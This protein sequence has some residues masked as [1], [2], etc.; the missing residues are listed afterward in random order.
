MA[1][2]SAVPERIVHSAVVLFSRQG[3]HGTSTR[4]IAQL[5]QVSEVTV[6]RYFEH[7]EDIFRSALDSSFSGVKPRLKHSLQLRDANRQKS[8]CR[9][10]LACCRT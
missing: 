5:A 8:C 7:K 6:Y 4:E 1:R 2:Q 3:Y 10:L 9:G